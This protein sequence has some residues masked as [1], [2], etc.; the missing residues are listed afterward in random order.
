MKSRIAC[1]G[2]LIS[3]FNCPVSAS[4]IEWS[5]NY[6]HE[7]AL[8]TQGQQRLIKSENLLG[9]EAVGDLVDIQYRIDGRYRHDFQDTL[10]TDRNEFQFREAYLE[11]RWDY[12][13][14]RAGKQTIVWGQADGIR[15]LDKIN[16]L[17]FR[18]FIPDDYDNSRI[19]R[20]AVTLTVPMGRGSE[21]SASVIPEH[22]ANRYPDPG[23]RFSMALMPE[24][25]VNTQVIAEPLHE[26]D[27]S[28]HDSDIA[29][30]Y[31]TFIGSWDI[32]LHGYR[33]YLADPAVRLRVSP[34]QITITPEFERNTM[35]GVG[36]NNAFGDFVFRSELVY[37]TSY[38]YQTLNPQEQ[39]LSKSP[40]AQ[41]V[42]GLDYSGISDNLLS[43]QWFQWRTLEH[44][45][46]F[47]NEKVKNTLTF[48]WR[49]FYMNNSLSTE[50][51]HIQ[52][53]NTNEDGLFRANIK[54]EL[55]DDILIKS[56]A[57]VFF[58]P[59]QGLYGQFNRKDQITAG[60][61]VSF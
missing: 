36:A 54:Y 51:L 58:G 13:S 28:L 27:L 55:T 40:E 25:P 12:A 8:A 19:A 20:T 5:G 9:I 57:D 48:L 53:L 3:A 26:P 17:N 50:I 11:K 23:Y 59:E 52:E 21:L 15:L 45:G 30:R 38:Y 2:L 60:I 6:E 29:V 39:F 44:Q 10:D 34:G 7:I 47:A 14:L 35:I 49:Q 33:H 31:A 43:V 4:E 56:G 32:A 61:E 41:S 1:L 22:A 37:N 42:L 24:F 46:D 18:E 16:S